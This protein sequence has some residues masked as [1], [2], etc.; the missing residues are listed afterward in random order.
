M[1][2]RRFLPTGLWFLTLCSIGALITDLPAQQNREFVGEYAGVLG[3]L[4]V[5]LHILAAADGSISANVDSPDQGMFGL[6]CSDL[7]INGQA[8]SFSVPNVRGEWTGVMSSDHNTLTGVWKQAGPMALNFTRV[9]TSAPGPAGAAPPA[10]AP[11]AS[12]AAVPARAACGSMPGSVSYWDGSGWKTMTM[13]AH[14][15][16]DRGVSL[17]NGLKNPFNPRAGITQIVTFKN[18][19]AMLALDPKP[20]F[21]LAIPPNIDPTV[22]MI[23]SVDVKKDHRELE[24]CAGPCASKGRAADDWMPEKRVQPVEIKRLSD[25]V[26]E[27]TPAN[28][29][30]TGQYIIGGPPMIGYYDF[31]VTEKPQ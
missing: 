7:T 27:I 18:A 26:V 20:R 16:S 22:V 4:H 10:P 24:T 28:P 2:W 21:C 3:P 30:K 13:A 11:P 25:N 6:P 8:L 31:G 5:K 29:L 1:D 17:K 15:G 12:A 14:L 19:S 23:G 9:S